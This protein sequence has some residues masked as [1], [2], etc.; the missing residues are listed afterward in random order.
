MTPVNGTP[1]SYTIYQPTDYIPYTSAAT[2]AFN[3]ISFN[4]SGAAVDGDAFLLG[5]NPT[6]VS[7]N[8][9][10]MLLSGLQTQNTID[11]GSATYQ[12][13]YTQIVSQIGNK[14]REVD[15]GYS[16]LENLVKQGQD[17]IQSISGVNLDEEAANMLRFQQAYQ[18]S[19]RM[20]EVSSKLFDQLLLLGR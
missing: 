13:A 20:I 19:A 3:G 16:A 17:A 6:G 14:A 5:P 2:V 15:V 1:T 9:N 7:D 8:R 12:S 10:A 11:A 18:A 4:I